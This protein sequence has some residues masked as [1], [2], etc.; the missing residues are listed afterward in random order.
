M[1]QQKESKEQRTKSKGKS[2]VR[3]QKSKRICFVEKRI[4][5]NNQFRR[6]LIILARTLVQG[7]SNAEK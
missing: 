3:N 6:N 1:V 5:L 2:K 4:V 7:D